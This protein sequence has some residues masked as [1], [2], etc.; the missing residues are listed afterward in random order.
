M[1]KD[2]RKQNGGIKEC[3]KNTCCSTEYR[4]MFASKS[5]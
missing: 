2:I 3:R 1:M 5:V 4:L